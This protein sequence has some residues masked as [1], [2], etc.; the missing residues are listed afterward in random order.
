MGLF[1]SE[2]LYLGRED[3]PTEEELFEAYCTAAQELEGRK[4]IIRTLD[5][6]ADKKVG[7]FQLPEEENPALGFRAI[8]ICLKRPEIFLTQLRA[9]LRASAYGEV[10]VMFPMIISVEEVKAARALL[11][12]AKAGL[13]AEGIPFDEKMEVGI[14]IETPAAAL[15]SDDLPGM[16]ISSASGPTIWSS[17][18]WRWTG[19]TPVW[20]NWG[21]PATRRCSVSST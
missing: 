4:L 18:P 14:M 15:I 11:E 20:K 7:Y 5:I 12:E 9:I 21:K 16:W 19:R 3:Y 13:R 17:I 2:F 6:G 1:R 10:A 8:R